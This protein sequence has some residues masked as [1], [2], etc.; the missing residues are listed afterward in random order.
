VVAFFSNMANLQPEHDLRYFS[1]LNPPSIE[2]VAAAGSHLDNLA[3]TSEENITGLDPAEPQF[4]EDLDAPQRPRWQGKNRTS[5][6]SRIL[7]RILC[8]VPCLSS[9]QPRQRDTPL[10]PSSLQGLLELFS[11]REVP[12]HLAL[13]QL[14]GTRVLPVPPGLQSPG[15]V[16]SRDQ[17]AE[18]SLLRQ[19][20][21]ML[22]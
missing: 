22:Q 11:K 2:S 4:I 17:A 8:R 9:P 6:P 10:L 20:V 7:D 16:Q 21:L 5:T 15:W 3:G 19:Q 1:E 18:R 12:V 13:N 14:G